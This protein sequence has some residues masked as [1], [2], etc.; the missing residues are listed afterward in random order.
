MRERNVKQILF[1]GMHLWEGRGG[2]ERENEREYAR[3]TL[4]TCMQ[5]EQ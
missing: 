1:W 5:I 4:Y 2:M 3:C